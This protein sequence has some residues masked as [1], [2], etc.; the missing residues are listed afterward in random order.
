MRWS[1]VSASVWW[2]DAGLAAVLAGVAL[3]PAL[4]PYGLVLGGLPTR[5]D[6]AWRVVLI[7]AQTLPLAG[8]A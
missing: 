3:V 5:S 7:L 6:D 2:R 8:R 1:R 4:G